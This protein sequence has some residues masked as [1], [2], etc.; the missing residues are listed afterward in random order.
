MRKICLYVIFI[1]FIFF[2]IPILL[3]ND[4]NNKEVENLQNNDNDSIETGNMESNVKEEKEQIKDTQ[5]EYSYG[6]YSKVKLLHKKTGKIEEVELDNYLLNVVSAEMPANYEIEA[7]KSQAIVA[8][9]YTI[10]KLKH[11]GKHKEERSR[12]LR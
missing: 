11:G 4:K 5:D 6:N 3:I 2:C 10:Y 1:V 9:T 7:L 12:Y 8:R